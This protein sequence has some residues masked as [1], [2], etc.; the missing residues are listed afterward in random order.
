MVSRPCPARPTRRGCSG[1]P[2]PGMNG[3]TAILPSERARVRHT[4]RMERARDGGRRS[5]VGAALGCSYVPSLTSRTLANRSV[6]GREQLAQLVD[7]ARALAR[8]LVGLRL[9]ERLQPVAE[10]RR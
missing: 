6:L 9:I 3:R 5:T 10:P 8:I 7:E 2:S 1:A 4:M